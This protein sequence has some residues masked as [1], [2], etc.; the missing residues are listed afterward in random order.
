MQQLFGNIKKLRE[1]RNFTQK[2]MAEQ[3]EMTQANYSKIESGET[4]VPYSRLEQIAKALKTSIEDL[5]SYNE[6]KV[7]STYFD[8]V[9]TV[10]TTQSGDILGNK[11][12][13]EEI[14]TLYE[15]RISSLEKEIERLHDLL[16]NALFTK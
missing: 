8:K 9:E 1:L 16:K 2:Y 13:I 4:D 5:V 3:L 15:S 10:Q 7:F 6:K 11:L 12:F 14:K